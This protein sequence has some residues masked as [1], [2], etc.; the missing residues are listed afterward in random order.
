MPSEDGAAP[1]ANVTKMFRLE[2]LSNDNFESWWDLLEDIFYSSNWMEMWN[3]A[4]TATTLPTLTATKKN[5]PSADRRV[6]WG[7]LK[8]HMTIDQRKKVK[9]A[10]T[11]NV[12][13]LLY[14]LRTA[15]HNRSEISLDNLRNQIIK[16]RLEDHA[17]LS[18]YIAHAEWIA[19][20]MG[21]MGR[22]Q[23]IGE[24]SF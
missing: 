7:L 20:R 15:H 12:E 16:A 3:K 8:S 5:K 17:D 18:T 9:K 24:K 14:L 22:E 10:G 21:E 1:S 11:G 6:A 23:T 4:A 2:L 19:R 13:A